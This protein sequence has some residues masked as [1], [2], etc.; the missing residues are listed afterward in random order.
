MTEL[1]IDVEKVCYVIMRARAFDAKV[2]SVEGEPGVTPADDDV[3]EV[4]LDRADDDTYNELVSFISD[5][6]V[7]EQVRLVA[8]AWLGRG[9]YAIEEWAEAR[10]EA[11]RGHNDRTA[12]Y[13]LGMPLLGDYLDEGL[14]AFGHS[15]SE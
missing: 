11:R 15:C 8:L 4:L 5:L 10:A 6:N 1:G 12:Q 7:D 13:L 9:S 3:S 2:G 14:A